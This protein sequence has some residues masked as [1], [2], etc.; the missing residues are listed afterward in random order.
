MS[1]AMVGWWLLQELLEFANTV[2]SAVS[3]LARV[4]L[5]QNNVGRREIAPHTLGAFAR[6]SANTAGPHLWFFGRGPCK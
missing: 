3:A 4:T 5:M 6:H 2:C 1:K